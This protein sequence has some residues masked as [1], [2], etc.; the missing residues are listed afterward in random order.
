MLAIYGR[1]AQMLRG[2]FGIIFEPIELD[3]G[4]CVFH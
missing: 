4:Q 2:I 3:G 1:I